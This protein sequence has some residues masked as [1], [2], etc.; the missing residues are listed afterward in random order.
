MHHRKLGAAE[1]SPADRSKRR[2]RVG[3]FH[4][5]EL[6]VGLVNLVF[7]S[8]AA[9]V[10]G[11]GTL[12]SDASVAELIQVE[13]FD[14]GSGSPASLSAQLEDLA[15]A[16]APF[17]SVQIVRGSA[18]TN[19]TDPVD[20]DGVASP[21]VFVD[22]G[23]GDY[24]VFVDKSGPGEE[25]WRLTLSCWTGAGGT[26]VE[27]GTLVEGWVDPVPLTGPW[28]GWV[29]GSGLMALGAGLLDRRRWKRGERR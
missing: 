1:K 21:Q 25:D 7:A 8:T 23:P 18:A 26:G 14:D 5:G 12:P 19:G 20:G 27:T 10:T 16:L 2:R 9:A 24:D 6:I 15:P 22:G 3:R 11:T 17:V 4:R 29:L 13:C 28:T